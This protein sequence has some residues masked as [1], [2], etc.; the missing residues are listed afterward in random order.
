M[1]AR[2]LKMP[3]FLLGQLLEL[4]VKK[5][6]YASPAVSLSPLGVCRIWCLADWRARIEG[7]QGQ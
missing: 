2:W 5:M 1:K 6:G 7:G 3:V 4:T